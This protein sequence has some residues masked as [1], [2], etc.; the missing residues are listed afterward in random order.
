MLLA[1]EAAL[2][3]AELR[4]AAAKLAL[5]LELTFPSL[6][7]EP[8]LDL[9]GA[10]HPLLVLD[11]VAVV[12]SDVKVKAAHALVVSGPNAG[13]KT[14]VLKTLGLTVLMLRAGL[15]VPCDPKS[16]VGIFE[17][18]ASDMGDEQS[19][20]KNLSTFSAH[21]RN[22][23]DI[24]ERTT[25][26]TLVLL[27]EIATG[28]EPRQGEALATGVLDGL[29][30]RGGAVVCTT[31]YEGLKSLAL[32]DER[33]HNAA[34]GFDIT[35]MSPTFR[36]AMGVPGASSALAIAKRFGMPSLIIERAERYLGAEERGFDELVVKLNDERRALEL[37]R[38]AVE[39]ERREIADRRKVL[40]RELEQT[41]KRERKMVS[42]QT[43]ALLSSVKRARDDLRAAQQRLRN[44]KLNQDTLKEVSHNIERVAAKVAV[45][46]EL[47]PP[48]PQPSGAHDATVSRP[49]RDGPA[50]LCSE[51]SERSARCRCAQQRPD[52]SRPWRRQG[53]R[54]CR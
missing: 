42:E 39:R 37:A 11:G 23:A 46:G 16:K 14:V 45:G 22:L 54:A 6:S 52:S 41:R 1:A 7:D 10:R 26:G 18:V 53:Q 24:L 15:P 36:L 51:A 44:R 48:H 47:E 25:R 3:H 2:G 34:V 19:I 28:T 9:I 21:V 13:G 38:S 31:H 27:D 5:D 8:T 49:D 17:S 50:C 12:A 32:G 43:Q 20:A 35:T 40:E 4:A 30:A 29:C 33:F